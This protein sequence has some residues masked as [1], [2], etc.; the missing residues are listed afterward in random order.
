MTKTFVLE[1]K[2]SPIESNAEQFYSCKTV[3]SSRIQTGIIR[4]DGKRADHLTT[5]TAA[6][7]FKLTLKYLPY[8]DKVPKT[9]HR[10]KV[11]LNLASYIGT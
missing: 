10:I 9:F 8:I 4:K 2:A 6:K 11:L 1:K 5:T 3:D 7:F